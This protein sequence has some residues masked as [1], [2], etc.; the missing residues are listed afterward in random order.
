MLYRCPK[1]GMKVQAWFADAPADDSHTYVSLRCPACARLHIV[2][3]S[4]RTLG[5]DIGRPL[6]RSLPRTPGKALLGC[7]GRG[8]LPPRPLGADHNARESCKVLM[9]SHPRHFLLWGF[10]TGQ[11]SLA[12]LR[13]GSLCAAEEAPAKGLTHRGLPASQIRRARLDEH[14]QAES[15]EASG[16]PR[17]KL[18]FSR[19]RKNILVEEAQ[20]PVV[21]RQ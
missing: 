17:P 12:P 14:G 13:R 21:V 4:G 6:A 7:S 3:R 18:R 16:G 5:N 1:T 9:L 15:F 19:P 2:N 20:H 11:R 8:I 10:E